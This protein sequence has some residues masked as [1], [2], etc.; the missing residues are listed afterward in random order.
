M[1]DIIDAHVHYWAIARGDYRWM[2]PDLPICRD[3]LPADGAPLF[4]AAGVDGIVLVQAADTE[5]ETHFMLALA[6]T[7]PRVRGVVGWIDMEAPDA[8]DRLARLADNRLLR[9]IRPMWQDIAED[10]WFLHERQAPAYRAVVELGLSFDAL[11]RVRHLPLL[12]RLVERHPDLPIVI[13]HAA[14]PEIA[15]GHFAPWR[16]DMAVMASFP[17]VMCKFSGLVT[18]AAP[19]AGIDA[20]SP[21][22]EALLE[23]FGPQRL[24]FGSD[25]PVVT[26]HAAYA[27]WWSWAQTL[28]ASLATP[29]RA[30]LFG[31]TAT[32]FYRLAPDSASHR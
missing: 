32:R 23:L 31:G 27:T 26:T 7:D 25:W 20:I 28:A 5:A 30:A 1:S 6:E 22:A 8:P 2:T 21:Y 11:A 17:H 19:G 18:E 4:A 12:P 9:G 29:D 13:D 24:I 14:K 10:D 15:A 16:R 3:F